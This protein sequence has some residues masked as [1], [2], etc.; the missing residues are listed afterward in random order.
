MILASST[1]RKVQ[2]I[3]PWRNVFTQSR[4]NKLKVREFF[5]GHICQYWQRIRCGVTDCSISVPQS[6]FEIVTHF[7]QE[8][9]YYA[10]IML[11]TFK[12]LLYSNHASIIGGSLHTLH[13][14]TGTLYISEPLTKC[15]SNLNLTA[16]VFD[17]KMYPVTL[18]MFTSTQ[19]QNF[20]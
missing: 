5:F 3:V 20:Y 11:N 14:N 9:T 10:G 4:N 8:L 1:K 12:Y 15:R 7:Q 19:Y 6:Y 2:R 16:L 18:V 13:Q 17:G